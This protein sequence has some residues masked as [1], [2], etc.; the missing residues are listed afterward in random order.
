MRFAALVAG[1]MALSAASPALAQDISVHVNEGGFHRHRE[2]VIVVHRHRPRP[3]V[4]H[5]GWRHRHY[6]RAAE[7][8]VITR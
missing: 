7:H 1:V 5:E 8:A 6:H 2:P 4:V 3:V